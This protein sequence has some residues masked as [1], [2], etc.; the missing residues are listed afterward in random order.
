MNN[1]EKEKLNKIAAKRL[2]S[3]ISKDLK[4]ELKNKWKNSKTYQ[5]WTLM[6]CLKA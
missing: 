4:N 2:C 3:K 5:T 1:I 6:I